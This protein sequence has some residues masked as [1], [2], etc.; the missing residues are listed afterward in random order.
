MTAGAAE[1]TTSAPAATASAAP[2]A[3][4]GAANGE[5]LQKFAG[6]LGDISPP[7]VIPGGRG[8]QV[9]GN[10]SD[11]LNIG[12]ALGRSCDVQHNQCANAANG[13]RNAGFSVGDCDTQNNGCRALIQ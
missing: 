3:D 1:A 12:A 10:N 9:V 6:A 11:F 4:N 2:A 5:N 7:P 8:F 13:N